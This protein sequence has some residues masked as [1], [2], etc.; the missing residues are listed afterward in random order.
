MYSPGRQNETL[1]QKQTNGIML[2]HIC[3]PNTW[4]GRGRRTVGVRGSLWS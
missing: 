2:M 3:H 4:E 1:F